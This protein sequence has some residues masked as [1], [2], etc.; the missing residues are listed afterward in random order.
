[1]LAVT[2]YCRVRCFLSND[3]GCTLLSQALFVIDGEIIRNELI[4]IAYVYR[5]VEVW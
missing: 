4:N 2:F 3:S 1:M 5:K